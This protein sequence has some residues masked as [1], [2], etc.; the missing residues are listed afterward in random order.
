MG[1]S[2][3][4]DNAGKPKTPRGRRKSFLWDGLNRG[5]AWLYGQLARSFL[6]RLFTSYRHVHV[7]DAHGHQYAGRHRCNPMSEGRQRV[8]RAVEKSLL[9][10]GICALLRG[11]FM[12]PTAC[13]GLFGLVFGL[14]GILAAFLAQFISEGYTASVQHYVTLG[15]IALVSL[16]LLA[17]NRPFA[18]TLHKS[19]LW[20]LILVNFLGIPEDRMQDPSPEKYYLAYFPAYFFGVIAAIGS[21]FVSP[22][23]ILLGMLLFG[24]AGMILSYP[25]T[26]VVLAAL[27]LPLVWLN[28]VFMALPV[29]LILVTWVGYGV[30]VLFLHRPLRFGFLDRVMLVWCIVLAGACL[31]AAAVSMET[32]WLSLCLLITFSAYFLIVNLMTSRIY[33]RRCL[34]GVAISVGVVMAMACLRL[35]PVDSL[36]WLEGSRAG[37]AIVAGFKNGIIKLSGLWAEHSELYLVLALPWLYAYMLHTKRLFGRIMGGLAICMGLGPILMPRSISVLF[38]VLGVTALFLLLVDHTWLSAGIVALPLVG[39]GVYW[40]SYVYPL[41]DALQTILSRSRLYKSQLTDSLWAM[42]LDHPGGIGAGEQAFVSVYPAYA[43]PDLGAVTDSGNLFFEI[44]LSFGWPGLILSVAAFLLFLQKSLTCLRHTTASAD[45]AMILGGLTSL[46][47][48]IVFGMVRSFITAPRVFFT[49][50]LVIALCSAYENVIFDESDVLRARW[51]NSPEQEDRFYCK[52]R[53]M[54]EKE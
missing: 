22:F 37:D 32:L 26:G 13:Y 52:G 17:T 44:V 53:N 45:R 42:C 7:W 47:G 12:C 39:C 3:Q 36:S 29:V 30:K 18:Q 43:A 21:V 31:T 54:Y 11:F 41:S 34:M 19:G 9:Y 40:I 35:V 46:T 5:T 8:V 6:G 49:V 15:V 38:C 10:R 4:P 1:K 25:E 2:N 51:T 33:I 14:L 16:P 23:A 48:M 50:I 28:Q 24:V 20:R 27:S